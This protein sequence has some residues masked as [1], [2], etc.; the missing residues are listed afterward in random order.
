MDGYWFDQRYYAAMFAEHEQGHPGRQ[1]PIAGCPDCAN[2]QLNK[3]SAQAIR[4]AD[5]LQQGQ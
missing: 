4:R 1:K 2:E 5:Q 3:E